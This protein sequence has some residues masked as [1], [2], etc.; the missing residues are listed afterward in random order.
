MNS[1]P[2]ISNTLLKIE[3]SSSLGMFARDTG[4]CLVSRIA[5][6]RS[7]DESREIS[8]AEI[9]EA[10]IF[11]F[12]APAIAKVAR[13]T[14]AKAFDI[15]KD[16]LSL[17][18][19]EASKL[20]S[21]K[22]KSV[23]LGKFGQ[24]A[25]TFGLILPLVY[26]IAPVR[27]LIT[28]S[29]TGKNEFTSVIE[30]NKKKDNKTKQGASK[31]AKNLI[32]NLSIISAAS[33]MATSAILLLS[34]KN[35]FYNKIEPALDKLIK[36]FDFTSGCDLENAHY[37]FLI[38]P[39]SIAGYFAACRD[40]YEVKENVRRFSI[41]VPL[42]FFGEALIKKPI[43]RAFDKLFKTNT[44]VEDVKGG[45][46]TLNQKEIL[47]KIE[48]ALQ[49]THLKSRNLAYLTV[50]TINT[51]TIAAAISLLNRISTK[52]AYT[53]N[54]AQKNK[55]MSNWLASFKQRSHNKVST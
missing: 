28:L 2:L 36:H 53:R 50:F 45:F 3:N 1:L 29:K 20:D 43:Y 49:K 23:K 9:T 51:M 18:L 25:T 31:Q 48:P 6:S 37:G 27:N 47:E 32:R 41:T 12:S 34:R 46:K 11:Y 22:F 16:T 15:S 10:L 52:K 14:F 39:A 35:G 21:S 38:Y 5:L 54:Q 17:S 55:G 4:G 26:G 13:S 33:L 24:I 42:L 44:I 19:D 40:K 7:K 8:F 30:L